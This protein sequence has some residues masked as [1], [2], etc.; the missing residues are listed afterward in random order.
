MD[1][2]QS[3]MHKESDFILY[4]TNKVIGIIDDP[5]DCKAALKDLKAAGFKTAEIEVLSGEEGAHRLDPTERS[6]DHWDVLPAGLRR[7]VTWKRNMSD[8]TN[9]K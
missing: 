9:R 3:E 2:K 5:G 4:P 1:D 7:Q 6:M 8:G